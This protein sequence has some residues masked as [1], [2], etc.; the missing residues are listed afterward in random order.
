[1]GDSHRL[2]RLNEAGRFVLD[3]RPGSQSEIAIEEAE[4][5]LFAIQVVGGRFAKTRLFRDAEARKESPLARPSLRDRDGRFLGDPVEQSIAEKIESRFPTLLLKTVDKAVHAL[6]VGLSGVEDAIGFPQDVDAAALQQ[7]ERLANASPRERSDSVQVLPI[8]PRHELPCG[9]CN[10]SVR[11]A[12]DPQCP[13]AGTDGRQ[14]APRCVVGDQEH[15]ARGRLL[16]DLQKRVG[17]VSVEIV[18]RI[19]NGDPPAGRRGRPEET[20]Q[21]A[22]FIDRDLRLE[23]AAS[24][25][26]TPLDVDDVG[27][28]AGGNLA[29]RCVVRVEDG[30]SL[31]FGCPGAPTR[32][33]ANAKASVALPMP[34]GP[35]RSQA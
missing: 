15:R 26:V 35:C 21:S 11:K 6:P 23:P 19:E 5:R 32:C 27:M 22:D 25:G 14:E 9:T 12:V 20:L 10:R 17:R 3:G 29:D 24:V 1:M 13:A 2:A 33:R 34:R 7:D 28:G 18:R 30:A 8:G 16:E 4:D 31:A